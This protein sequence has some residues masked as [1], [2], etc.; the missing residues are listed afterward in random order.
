MR[1]R[2]FIVEYRD[3]GPAYIAVAQGQQ[4]VAEG[5]ESVPSIGINVRNDGDIDYASLIVD[6]KKK[7][8]SR[9]TDSLRPYVGK[10]VAIVR[11]GSGPATAIGQVTIGEPIVVNAEKFDKLRKQHLVPQGSKFDIEKD[12]TKYLYPMINP[13]RWYN[14]K[15]VQHKGIVARKIQE[16][17]DARVL[18]DE[19]TEVNI[20]RVYDDDELLVKQRF[21]DYF[22]SKGYKFLGDGRDQIALLSPRETVLKII[23]RG[24]R[25]RQRAVEEY[26]KFFEQ[27]Q[28]NPYYPR[29]YNSQRFKLDNDSYFLYETEYLYHFSSDDDVLDWIEHYLNELAHSENDAHQWAETNGIPEEIGEDNL[30]GLLQATLDIMDHLVGRRGYN[31]DLSNIEN[32][33]RRKDGHIVICDPISL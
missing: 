22:T 14:E 30:Y 24:P 1:A 4:G 2:E 8:E 9:K 19:L 21:V 18:E 26:V 5:R 16:V 25:Q 33:R 28:N 31:L 13:S 7:Y 3:R 11:T 32:I 17:E 10:T 20:D 15:V 29:I 6:G 12:S 27:R 23:G